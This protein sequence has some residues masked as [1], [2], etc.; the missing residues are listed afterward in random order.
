VSVTSTAR[1]RS[2]AVTATVAGPDGWT[3]QPVTQ[4]LAPGEERLLSVPVT[5]SNV[6]QNAE[7]TVTVTS[8]AEVGDAERTLGVVAV[9]RGSDVPLALDGGAVGSPVLDSWSALTPATAWSE[10]AGFGWVGTAPDD[11]DRNR[12]DVLRR[13]FVLGRDAEYVLRV[14]VP[15]GR[16][17]AYVLTGDAY[18]QSG[19]T[20]ILENGTVLG[21]SP[22][23][24]IPQGEFRWFSFEIDGGETGR[25]A[26][27]EIRGALRDRYWRVVALVLQPES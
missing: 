25:T 3:A 11:R 9:P 2:I 12:L 18:A 6:P 10:Q 4:T 7:L 19:T 17:R 23:E 1:D 24:I 8:D 20:T 21:A 5:P 13:D 27:L 22:D 16:H 14:A 26:D 15:A